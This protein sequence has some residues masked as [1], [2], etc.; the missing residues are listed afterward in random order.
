MIEAIH[1]HV[2]MI[3]VPFNGD[4]NTNAAFI[5][6]RNIGLYIK[7]DDITEDVFTKMIKEVTS[8]PKSVL[9]RH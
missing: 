2:P 1:F 5:E 4:Q 8:N 3:C 7:S 9:N 6:S